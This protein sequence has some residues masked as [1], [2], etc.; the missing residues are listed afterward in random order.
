MKMKRVR[1][2]LLMPTG[3]LVGALFTTFE[4]KPV[5]ALDL[6]SRE[7]CQR[8]SNWQKRGNS[9]EKILSQHPYLQSHKG[10]Y[11]TRIL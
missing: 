3:S 2:V 11:V 7:Q 8:H 10:A 4:H 6:G 1:D 5:T 9:A